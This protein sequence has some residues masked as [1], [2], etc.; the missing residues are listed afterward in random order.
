MKRHTFTHVW[1]A[2]GGS[3]QSC[4]HLFLQ[5]LVALLHDVVLVSLPFVEFNPV[6]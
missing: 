1:F 4:N 5:M 6:H 2:V 3:R